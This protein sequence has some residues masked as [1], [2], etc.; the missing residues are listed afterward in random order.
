MVTDI[1]FARIFVFICIVSIL[2][3]CGTFRFCPLLVTF[4]VCFPASVQMH[5]TIISNVGE[6][7]FYIY[8]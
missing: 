5:N 8:N 3:L 2:R 6:L 4:S 1:V 7:S